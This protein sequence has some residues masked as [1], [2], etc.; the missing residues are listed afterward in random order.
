MNTIY[1][2]TLTQDHI[3]LLSNFCV[4]W[5]DC[6]TG[7]PEIDPKRPYGNSS[8]AHDVAEILR[9]EIKDD[10]LTDEQGEV[11]MKLHTETET[12]LQIALNTLSFTPGIYEK[13]QY[14]GSWKKVG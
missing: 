2:F 7:A 9:W 8:V 10:E 3:T 6:E 4:G 13:Q 11:A 14:G 1:R 12:A 5:Q